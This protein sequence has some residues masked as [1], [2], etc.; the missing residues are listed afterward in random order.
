M[1][2]K[3]DEEWL[4]VIKRQICV[5]SIETTKGVLFCCVA[6]L[7]M[8]FDLTVEIKELE[9]ATSKLNGFHCAGIYW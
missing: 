3:E 4:V 5:G 7:L 9:I 1:R 8:R 6:S 2:D